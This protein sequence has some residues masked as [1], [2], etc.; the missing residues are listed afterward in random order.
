MEAHSTKCKPKTHLST[1]HLLRE[2]SGTLTKLNIFGAAL[3]LSA[4]TKVS[5]LKELEP[6]W[7]L[8][9]FHGIQFII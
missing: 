5:I 6:N 7:H 8:P 1:C 9:D 3:F 4:A 2:L